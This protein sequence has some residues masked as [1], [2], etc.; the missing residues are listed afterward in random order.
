MSNQVID[1][2]EYEMEANG[3]HLIT[4]M[5]MKQEEIRE[6]IAARKMFASYHKH[7]KKE[8]E[9][10]QDRADEFGDIASIDPKRMMI[11]KNLLAMGKSREF[12]IAHTLGS[13]VW[14]RFFGVGT[15]FG[16]DDYILDEFGVP[17]MEK[18]KEVYKDKVRWQRVL[19]RELDHAKNYEKFWRHCYYF[20]EDKLERYSVRINEYNS[21]FLMDAIE[22]DADEDKTFGVTGI[23]VKRFQRCLLTDGE[24]TKVAYRNGGETIRQMGISMKEDFDQRNE[25][26]GAIKAA[27]SEGWGKQLV[28]VKSK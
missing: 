16:G 25:M 28:P 19:L 20:D 24:P 2:L 27:N 22:A 17:S 10:K 1:G 18:L 9:R 8:V 14:M 15:K 13:K 4:E 11:L 7:H 26:I 3:N 21:E 12:I 23:S 5:E 6:F